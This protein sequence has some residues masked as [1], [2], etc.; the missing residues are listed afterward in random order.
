MRLVQFGIRLDLAEE[1]RIYTLGQKV[2]AA[3]TG[4]IPT[5]REP[6]HATQGVKVRSSKRK[7]SIMWN[8][9]WF[10]IALEDVPDLNKA[11]ETILTTVDQI[12]TVVPIY[13]LSKRQVST[14]WILPAPNYDFPSLERRYREKM[15]APNEISNSAADSS[16]VFDIRIGELTLHHQ[17]GPM[18]PQ[19]LLDD[20][21]QFEADDIPE[22]FLFLEASIVE[23]KVVEYSREE[24]LKHLAQ[25][26]EHCRFHSDAFQ[27]IWKEIL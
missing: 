24:T 7:L 18:W 25:A 2:V 10:S 8:P 12:S 20:Y 21:L 26:F 14:Y 16:A 17:S 15:L 13:K 27:R 11:A 22:A 23:Q 4:K 19:Q 5:E 9:F 3:I 6:E 1:R